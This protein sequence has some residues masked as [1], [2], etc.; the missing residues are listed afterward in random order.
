M[1][2]YGHPSDTSLED[3]YEVAKNVNQNCAANEAF[4]LAY[5]APEPAPACL[6]TILVCVASQSIFRPQAATPTHP[7]PGN[8]VPMDIDRS[9]WKNLN[10]LTC[11]RCHQPGH[12]V[13][14]CPLNFNIRLMTIEELEM[15]LMVKKDMAQVGELPPVLEEFI[16]PQEDFVQNNEWQAHP[17]CLP[18]IVDRTEN[19]IHMDYSL[20]YSNWINM[21]NNN[22]TLD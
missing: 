2:A 22:K 11:Y 1:M 8:S 3:W 13:P 21:I 19:W 7:T 20:S 12:K 10:S 18:V 17:H 6:T 9:W 16:K 15:E 14:D 4:K 5:Q